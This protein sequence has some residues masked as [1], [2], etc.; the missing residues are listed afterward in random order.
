MIRNKEDG[1]L[2]KDGI[3]WYFDV[4]VGTSSLKHHLQNGALDDLDKMTLGLAMSK[5]KGQYN[6]S[7]LGG[8][9]E[10]L[11]PLAVLAFDHNGY[12]GSNSIKWIGELTDA[13]LVD[14]FLQSLSYAF[15]YASGSIAYL[16]ELMH[17]LGK[18]HGVVKNDIQNKINHLLR[19]G[20][21]RRDT[22][23]YDNIPPFLGEDA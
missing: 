16:A 10:D 1:K 4:T 5:L 21:R 2:S 14:S 18:S 3:S 19:S 20:K 15:A 13:L 8:S 11:D 22:R 12:L 17:L 9:L 6:D 23:D 7:C